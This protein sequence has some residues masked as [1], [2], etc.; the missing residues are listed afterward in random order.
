MLW[1]PSKLTSCPSTTVRCPVARVTSERVT[2]VVEVTM[3]SAKTTTPRCTIIPPVDGARSTLRHDPRRSAATK[4]PRNV[5]SAAPAASTARKTAITSAGLR[6]P[7]TNS[8]T[9]ARIAVQALM[10]VRD[11]STFASAL[12][13]LTSGAIAI[14]T[15]KSTLRGAATLAK[16]GVPTVTWVPLIAW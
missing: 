13:Q 2:Y 6:T 3:P 14:N 4:D 16:Y 15:N 5:R 12:R 10:R 1:K 9:T 7:A 8:T 11:Q